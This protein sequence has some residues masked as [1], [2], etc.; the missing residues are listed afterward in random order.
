MPR[1]VYLGG[2]GRSGTT[3]LER[4]L[5]ELPG[6]C[7]MGEVVHLWQ[8]G[9]ADGERCGCG[10]SFHDCPFW[11]KVGQA[12]FDGWDHLDLARIA[13]LRL[14][15]DR[16]RSIPLLAAPV[17]PGSLRRKVAEYAGYFTRVYAAV[18]EVSG[19]PVVVD[20]SKHASLAFCLRRSQDL[21][22]RVVHVVRDSRAVAFSWTRRVVRP[23]SAS[24]SLM[25]MYS[26]KKASLL[27]DAQNG[28]MQLLAAEGVPTLRVRYEDLV[29]TPAR[30]LRRIAGFAGIAA[31]DDAELGFMGSD[32]GGPWAELSFSHTAS[33]NPMRFATGRIPIRPDDRWRR[34]MPTG[35]R[36]AVTA[37]TLPLLGWYGYLPRQSPA[38]HADGGATLARADDVDME[39]GEHPATD[40]IAP[41]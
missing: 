5:G 28:A 33:G 37:M 27:W 19:C 21:N 12:A 35:Q 23:D 17:L 10:E 31:D 13:G 22:L 29:T 15:V 8:R 30:T 39:A 25:Q 32:A 24:D 6:V 18:S 2:L 26:P 9:V 4:L 38:G 11:S 3:L 1:V 41:R 40:L 20:S 14:A 7:S 16:N 36:R 34:Q